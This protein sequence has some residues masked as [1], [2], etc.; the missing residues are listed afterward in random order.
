MEKPAGLA[1]GLPV[2]Y[3]TVTQEYPLL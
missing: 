3:H 2:H 1:A